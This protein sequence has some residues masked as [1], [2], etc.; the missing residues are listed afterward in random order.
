LV[1]YAWIGFLHHLFAEIDA[2]Q[3]V[4]KDVVVKHV[5][6]RFTEVY[7]PFSDVGRADAEGHILRV[8]RASGVVVAADSADTAGDEVGVSRIFALHKNTVSA[9]DGRRA[10][11]LRDLSVLEVNL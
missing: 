1:Q 5:L 7:D 4:L 9:K 10:V 6:C 8:G 2:N 11:A 3:I